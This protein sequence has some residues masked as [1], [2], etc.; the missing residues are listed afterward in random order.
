[1]SS[2][3]NTTCN[4]D[5]LVDA[6]GRLSVQKESHEE[7]SSF[8]FHRVSSAMK[9]PELKQEL[10][11]RHPNM[12]GMS[13]KTKDWF[14]EELGEG[15]ICESC[16]SIYGSVVPRVTTDMTVPELTDELRA[17]QPS[18]KTTGRCKDW[19]LDQLVIGTV[20]LTSA[21]WEMIVQRGYYYVRP[22]CCVSAHD[23]RALQN[24]RDSAAFY[25]QE[26]QRHQRQEQLRKLQKLK[27]LEL[28]RQ[29]QCESIRS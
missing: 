7:P 4:L 1:M 18:A 6:F 12:K 23:P 28:E 15:S 13:N 9:I 20:R 29:R 22:N 11:Y 10:C 26:K 27:M 8:V 14:L 3:N 21:R 16:L 2:T 17:R 5:D 25:D 24:K 19:F